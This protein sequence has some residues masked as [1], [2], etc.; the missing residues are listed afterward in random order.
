MLPLTAGRVVPHHAW[1]D[2]I[3]PAI[4]L[5]E[6]AAL[7]GGQIEGDPTIILQGAATLGRAQAGDITLVDAPRLI[8]Q[9]TARAA[10]AAIV[11]TDFPATDIPRIVVQDVHAAFAK[12]VTKFRPPRQPVSV[13]ISP[14]AHI[15]SSAKL[16]P[17]VEVHPFATLGED[18]IV[19]SGA[20]IHAGVHIMAG[21]RIG[22][23][24]TLFPNV[25]LY[26]GTIVGARSIIHA[27]AAIGAFGFGYQSVDGAHHRGAQL[28]HVEIGADVEVGAGTTIDRGTYDATVI[29]DGTKI[30]N[31][32]MIGHNCQVG[33]HNLICSQV[34]IAGSCT[35]GDYVV[36]A[37]QVGLSDHL[38]IGHRA[39]L[40]AKAGLMNDVPDGAVFIGVPATPERD[41][42]RMWGHVRQLPNMRRQLKSLQQRLS[43]SQPPSADSDQQEAA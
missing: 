25:V 19:E 17:N 29:G 3:V 42:W 40:G 27:G 28:G 37:G 41:Q 1:K 21:C 10:T 4:T 33:K 31:Q 20:V 30:D 24:V 38:H 6:L 14:S 35:T 18:V 32:V 7:V 36:M 23:D 5:Q 39:V 15:A 2:P 11:P 43:Q 22:E 34:G 8:P 13:G 9:L 26:E 16:A 12:I